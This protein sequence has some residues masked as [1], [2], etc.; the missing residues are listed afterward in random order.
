MKDAPGGLRD[1]SAARIIA[2]VTDPS[3]LR[4]GGEDAALLA[5]A[6]DFLLREN[7]HRPEYLEQIMSPS[8][9]PSDQG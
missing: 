9:A 6:E 4:R 2:A 7:R 5:L 8:I 1:I 3:L